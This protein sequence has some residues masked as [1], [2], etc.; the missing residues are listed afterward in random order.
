MGCDIKAHGYGDK[1]DD[2]GIW[3]KMVDIK[4]A[5]PSHPGMVGPPIKCP[6]C[7]C[8]AQVDCVRIDPAG[9]G[10]S[11]IFTDGNEPRYGH[12]VYRDEN[13]ART[14]VGTDQCWCFPKADACPA[15][16]RPFES[17]REIEYTPFER[18]G[19]LDGTACKN[20]TSN[21]AP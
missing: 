21:Q 18:T 11:Y 1:E 16:Y 7:K 6:S 15:G 14:G 12:E 2:Q 17:G 3:Y 8:T 20:P 9:E 10:P 4:S 5:C 19:K 13:G